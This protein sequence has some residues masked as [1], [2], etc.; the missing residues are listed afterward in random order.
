MTLAESEQ[1]RRVAGEPVKLGDNQR[2]PG[3]LGMGD[4]ARQFRPVGRLARLDSR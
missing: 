4:G 1:E 3:T 2:G